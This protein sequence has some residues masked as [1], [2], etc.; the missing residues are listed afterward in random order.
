[1]LH[2]PEREQ[3]S[4]TVPDVYYTS[5][6]NQCKLV[7]RKEVGCVFPNDILHE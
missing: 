5:G 1:M 6:I 7:S 3:F 2:I 4:T